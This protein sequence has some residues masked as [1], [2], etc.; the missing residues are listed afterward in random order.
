MKYIKKNVGLIKFKTSGAATAAES[1]SAQFDHFLRQM[2][3]K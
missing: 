3:I 1:A 2:K